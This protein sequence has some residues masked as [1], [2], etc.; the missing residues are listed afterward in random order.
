[1]ILLGLQAIGWTL[2]AIGLIVWW[3][4]KGI[5]ESLRDW[6]DTKEKP[7][8]RTVSKSI[9]KKPKTPLNLVVIENN[10]VIKTIPMTDL[11]FFR[12]GR[13]DNDDLVLKNDNYVS[14]MHCFILKYGNETLYSI[15]D[16]DS[17]N[18]T[19]LNDRKL[20]P[21]EHVNLKKGDIIR[22]AFG[23]YTLKVE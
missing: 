18:G 17:T 14:L 6:E 10:T 16:G 5:K 3:I 19:Y 9:E 20:N 2:L 4:G 8:V 13:D 21:N 23:Y 22:L 7:R 1:M 11:E 15:K 12:I